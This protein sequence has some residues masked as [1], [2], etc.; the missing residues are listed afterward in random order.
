MQLDLAEQVSWIQKETQKRLVQEMIYFGN[1]GNKA[2]LLTG[3]TQQVFRTCFKLDHI[4]RTQDQYNQ[5][6]E[7]HRGNIGQT[8]DEV[9]PD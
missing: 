3:V 2:D 5:F 9:I 4:P 1:I 6:K 8:F 7:I